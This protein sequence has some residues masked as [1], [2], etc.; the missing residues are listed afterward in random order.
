[1]KRN[2]VRFRVEDV[3]EQLPPFMLEGGNEYEYGV[4]DGDCIMPTTQIIPNKVAVS[5]LKN[6][7]KTGQA[8]FMDPV[9]LEFL[10]EEFE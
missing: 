5:L 1:M 8:R 10:E 9:N 4:Y 6:G 3:K 7:R 2:I